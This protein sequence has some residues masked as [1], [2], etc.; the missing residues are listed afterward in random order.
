E[1]LEGVP[2][3]RSVRAIVHC[4][5]PRADNTRLIAVTDVGTAV[6]HYLAQPLRQIVR[7]A[8]FLRRHGTRDAMLVLVGSTAAEP[9]RHNFRMPLYS[10]GKSLLPLL[11]RILAVELGATGQRCAGVTFDVVDAGMNAGI[12]KAARLAHADRVP[13]GQ[14]PTADDAAA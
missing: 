8:Q 5:W 12:S 14:M 9:G 1:D 11:C 13:S 10:L 7:L 2:V 3:R 6:E 4:A